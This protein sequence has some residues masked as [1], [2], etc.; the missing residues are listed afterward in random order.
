MALKDYSLREYSL[1]DRVSQLRQAYFRAVPEICVERPRLITE[2]SVR[3]GF[4]ERERI[5]VLDKARTYRYVLEKRVPVVRHR[6]AYEKG[7]NKLERFALDDAS[8]FAGSTTSKFKGVPLYPEFLA[9]T[10]WPELWSISERASNPYQITEEEAKKLNADIFPQWMNHS[11]LELARKRCV[12]EN[13]RQYGKERWA[14]EIDLG[15][16]LV[17]F[18]ASKPNCIS[19]TIPDFS[20]AIR[21]GLRQIIEEAAAKQAQ[22]S[23]QSGKEFYR[24]MAEVLEGIIGYANHLAAEAENLARQE[25]DTYR[26]QGLTDIARIYRTVPEFPARTFREGLTT[27]WL[28][29][30]A[31]HLENPNVGLSLGRLDQVLIDLYRRDIENGVITTGD[32]IEMV[33]CLWL[34]IGDHVPTVP[35]AGEQLFGGTGS[36]QAIT[37]GGVDRDGRDAVND[38]TYV[39]LRATEMMMLRD[40]NLN[41]R[42]CSGT[43]PRQYLRRL[44]EVNIHT[45][46]TPALHNDHAVIKALMSKGETLAQARD[47][48]I[49]GCVEPGSNGRFY[50]HTGAI[51]LNLAS[52][53]ELTLFNGRHRHTGMNVLISKETGAPEVFATFADFQAAFA[54]Q[55]GWM[56]E[57]VTNLNNILGRIHQDFYPSPIL[58]ALF[59]GPMEKG[60][61]L[62]EGGAQINSSGAAIIGF[63]DVVDSLSAIEE[64]VFRSKDVSLAQLRDA[65]EANFVGYGALHARLMNSEKTPKF[66]N[67]NPVA[68]RNARWLTEL[69]DREFG[70]RRNYRGGFYRVGYWTMTNHA[71]FGRLMRAL[72]SGRKDFESFAS[73]ITPTSGMTPRLVET[74]NSVA[75]LPAKYLSDGIALNLK[76]TPKDGN[77][78]TM[79]DNLTAYVEGYFD[80]AGGTRDGGMEVQFN[81]IGH[82]ELIDAVRHPEN[83]PELLVRV[84]GYTAYFKDLNPQMQKEI[85]DR[86]EYLLSGGTAVPYEPFPLPQKE[87]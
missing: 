39:I 42:Y 22:T 17:F 16:R 10:L 85:I 31:I 59:E 78:E 81:I 44:C 86:T 18:L 65:M 14:P 30:I 58:S 35:Q 4:F 51:L 75:A 43:N 34:K 40:P 64:L 8:L 80:D 41:A 27:L 24:A 83:H 55:V 38:L 52:I 61:D 71:G 73:G 3:E 57:Q 15:Q 28:C 5:S 46:A 84:S 74:L 6:Y 9:L 87:G 56:V 69:L 49:T 60:K 7:E 63:A 77:K 54:A 50:G 72:P 47:Y 21:R 53:L 12:A 66:G 25:T 2:F 19:H 76:F 1:T 26:K 79:L 67:E 33:C 45:H 82:E 13:R 20:G 62:I 37:V 29:W 23:N 68:D 48:G 11:I 36:N 32:A 70:Q